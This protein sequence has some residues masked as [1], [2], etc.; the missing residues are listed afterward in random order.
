MGV[1]TAMEHHKREVVREERWEGRAGW[2]SAWPAGLGSLLVC[3]WSA[4]A[5]SAVPPRQPACPLARPLP[6]H[7]STCIKQSPLPQMPGIFAW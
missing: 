5:A 7:P 4:G 2:L 3:C 1:D 6:A